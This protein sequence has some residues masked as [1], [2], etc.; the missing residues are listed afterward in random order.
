LELVELQE[1]KVL[2]VRLAVTVEV[3]NLLLLDPR[4]F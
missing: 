3:D 1:L 2:P 4:L